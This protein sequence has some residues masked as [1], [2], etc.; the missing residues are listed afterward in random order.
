MFGWGCICCG[1]WLSCN[2]AY[3]V[4][5]SAPWPHWHGTSLSYMGLSLPPSLWRRLVRLMR[6]GVQIVILTL[7]YL[8]LWFLVVSPLELP[9]NKGKVPGC[10]PPWYLSFF[11][12]MFQMISCVLLLSSKEVSRRQIPFLV[13]LSLLPFAPVPRQKRHINN[14]WFIYL[15][16]GL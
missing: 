8:P 9:H 3:G 11:C 2:E 14:C 5:L 15:L 1:G 7:L 10:H 16:A 4:A 13:S 6:L 12:F